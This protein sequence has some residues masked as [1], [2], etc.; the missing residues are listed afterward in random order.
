VK[1]LQ[2]YRD[3][4]AADPA[5][6]PVRPVVFATVR[7]CEHDAS[8]PRIGDPVT[9]SCEDLFDVSHEVLLQMLERYFAHTEETD[10]QLAT[11]ADAA[12]TL[13]FG[14]LKPLG[15]LITTLPVGPER[16][17][18]TTGPSFELFYENDHLMPHREAARALLEERLREVASYCRLIQATASERVASELAPVEEA[19]GGVADSLAAHF[20]DWG[21][22][23]RFAAPTPESVPV[24]ATGVGD[25]TRGRAGGAGERCCRKRRGRS[26]PARGPVRRCSADLPDRRRGRGRRA[27]AGRL[28]RGAARRERAAPARRGCDRS[29]ARRDRGGRSTG[30]RAGARSRARGRSLGARASGHHG[31]RRAD[32]GSARRRAVDGGDCGA[33]AA[34]A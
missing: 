28:G 8:V 2:Q 14:L 7:H 16:P 10:E 3:M 32:L 13:M 6:D 5:F 20:A 34:R 21:A 18:M 15:D 9:S 23:S 4:K 17:G 30:T 26:E 31:V 24:A 1:I 33:P 22:V 11:L 27:A 25:E 12:I 19:L 29:P